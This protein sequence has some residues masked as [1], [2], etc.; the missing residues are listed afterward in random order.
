MTRAISV[1]PT[2]KALVSTYSLA[3]YEEPIDLATD[4]LLFGL[5]T[6]LKEEQ[7]RLDSLQT[8]VVDAVMTMASYYRD[9]EA[10]FQ[11]VAKHIQ[12]LRLEWE[13]R[14]RPP[15]EEE[16]AAQEAATAATEST[17]GPAAG[18]EDEPPEEH[19]RQCAIIFRRIARK[20]HPDKTKDTKLHELFL[21][22]KISYQNQDLDA[23]LVIWRQ[24]ESGNVG[25]RAQ[26]R[27]KS[28]KKKLEEQLRESIA[29]TIRQREAL[30]QQH[31]YQ[32]YQ[33]YLVSPDAGIRAYGHIA[34]QSLHN[35]RCEERQL[36]MTLYPERFQVRF[37]PS[38][39]A[40][41]PY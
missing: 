18:Q 36:E 41:F 16:T 11:K 40:T 4:A 8:R 2:S 33:V 37:T 30:M 28:H 3:L 13:R 35:A 14:N 26:R 25:N 29:H 24:V 34:H 15:P 31:T 32:L 5:E 23:L 27:S 1:R 10:E 22:A 12:E 21:A 20:T 17:A 7:E 39:T 19:E 38:T 6:T 9:V